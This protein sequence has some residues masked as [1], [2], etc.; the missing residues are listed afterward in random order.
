MDISNQ[1]RSRREAMG[2]SQE[3]LAT[4]VYV[5]RQSVSNWERDRT[6]PDVQSLLIL[7]EPFGTSLDT[8]VKGDVDVMDEILEM[9]RRTR[10][11]LDVA[12]Y[13][14]VAVMVGLCLAQFFT[15]LYDRTIDMGPF[16]GVAIP[17]LTMLFLMAAIF[18]LD[19]KER[20]ILKR[21]DIETY[22]ELR[23]FQRGEDI[24]RDPELRRRKGVLDA[25]WVPTGSKAIL[26]TLI[27][28]GILGAVLGFLVGCF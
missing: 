7:S 28:A 3:D 21:H 4:T 23:A 14:I 15:P 18:V 17:L 5:S 16:F 24:D 11:M 9:D 27:V 1:I 6:Y 19:S 13:L 12:G 20:T 22:R 25:L 10:R 8:L 26:V 2:L